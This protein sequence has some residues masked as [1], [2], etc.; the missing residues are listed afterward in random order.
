L[1][2]IFTD[3]DSVTSNNLIEITFKYE[4]QLVALTQMNHYRLKIKLPLRL[5]FRHTNSVCSDV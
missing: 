2:N 1:I 3:S 4:L 5:R